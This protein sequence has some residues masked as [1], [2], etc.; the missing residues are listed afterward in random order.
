MSVAPPAV[1]KRIRLGELL[2]EQKQL[3]AEQLKAALERQRQTGGMLGHLLIELGFVEED[4]LLNVLAAQLLMPVIDLRQYL[5]VPEVVR[6]LPE[7]HARR[8]RAIVLRNDD[9]GLVVGMVDPTDII[10]YDNLARILKRPIKQA[11]VR[12]S[13]VLQAIDTVYRRTEEIVTLAEELGEEMA[14][15]Q[16][17]IAQLTDATVTADD[18]PVVRL[19]Q[20]MF[21]DATQVHAS[22]IHIEPEE[23]LLRVRQRIDGFLHEQIIEETRIASALV[24]RLKLMSGLDISEK[25]LPQDGRFQIKVKN[26]RIDIRLSTMPVAHGESIVMR[27]LDQSGDLLNLS[28]LGIP[29]EPRARLERLVQRPNGMVLVTGPTGSGKTTT[30]YA[31]LKTINSPESK[32]ITVEDPVEYRMPRINQVQVNPRIELTFA[33]VLR[34][35]LRQDPD[36]IMVGEMRDPETAEIGVR[37]AMTGHLVLSTLHTNDSISTVSRLVDMGIPGYMV[38]TALNAV[39][40]QRLVRRVCENCAAPHELTVGE[41]V[42]LKA[43]S[44]GAAAHGTFRHGTGCQY[45]NDTGFRGRIGLYELLE[46]DGMLAEHLRRQDYGAFERAAARQPGFRPLAQSGMDFVLQGVTTIA[47]VI[48]VTGTLEDQPSYVQ[49]AAARPDA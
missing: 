49:G 1:R 21:E 20:S 26:A 35:A 24:T 12:E 42:W 2:V 19:L 36:V 11:I 13:E 44:G 46:L 28:E 31:A 43:M 8:H 41:A 30:L 34:S 40:A 23:N 45:C 32:I 9:D 37:A 15:G 14:Q 48:R 18:A 29:P 4:R 25:R 3:T 7:A 27:L 5:F 38:A 16:F 10:A 33:R 22:D 47:E 17:D 39:V 6:L